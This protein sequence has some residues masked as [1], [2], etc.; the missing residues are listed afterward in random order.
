ME[1]D[2]RAFLVELFT[3]LRDDLLEQMQDSPEPERATSELAIYEALLGGLTGREAF[4]N[5]E[6]T[7]R[8]VTALA[9]AAEEGNAYEQAA[10]EHRAFAELI[11]ALG[12]EEATGAPMDW[13]ALVVPPATYDSDRDHRSDVLDQPAAIGE[14][15]RANLR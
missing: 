10:L 9:K 5:D 13:E 7:R 3:D 1:G 15:A 11:G 14:T 12:G 8:F 6:G 4:P 2:S